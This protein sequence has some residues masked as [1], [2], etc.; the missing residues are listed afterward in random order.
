MVVVVDRVRIGGRLTSP[1][2]EVLS[3]DQA[4]VDINVGERNGANL[5]EIKIESGSVNLSEGQIA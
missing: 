1:T 5:L 3:T 2:L 4:C